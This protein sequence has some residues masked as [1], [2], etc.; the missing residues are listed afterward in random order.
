M[1]NSVN[2][3]SWSC[4]YHRIAPDSLIVVFFSFFVVLC[5]VPSLVFVLCTVC[6]EIYNLYIF[7]WETYLHQKTMFTN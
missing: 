5:L 7:A 3:C 6:R 4:F 1:I 2:N